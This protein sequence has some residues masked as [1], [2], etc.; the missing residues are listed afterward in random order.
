ME[1][2]LRFHM[3][4]PQVKDEELVRFIDWVA[5]GE[6][7]PEGLGKYLAGRAELV[8]RV[9]VKATEVFPSDTDWNREYLVPLFMVAFG[10]LRFAPQLGNQQAAVG[11]VQTLAQHIAH[12]FQL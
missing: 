8:Q 6:V 11:F 1:C 2:N 3:V 7:P 9:R 4:R 5:W 12:K 10:L